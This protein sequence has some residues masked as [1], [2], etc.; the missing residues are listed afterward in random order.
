MAAPE[1]YKMQFYRQEP[2]DLYIDDL[3]IGETQDPDGTVSR[4]LLGYFNNKHI[5]PAQRPHHAR[6]VTIDGFKTILTIRAT[7]PTTVERV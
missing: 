1:I 6:V 2:G 3:P 4:A 7:G 5:S